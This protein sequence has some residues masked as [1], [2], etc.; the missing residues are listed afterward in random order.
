MQKRV[1][2]GSIRIVGAAVPQNF[3]A[4]DRRIVGPQFGE[5]SYVRGRLQK[6]Q[7]A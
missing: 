5:N 6:V 2:A 4:P 7:S 1:D 3:L